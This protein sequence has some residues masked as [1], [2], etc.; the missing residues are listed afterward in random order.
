MPVSKNRALELIDE[1]IKQFQHI[2]DTATYDTR[3]N[4]EYH[5]AY[6]GAES[7]L[8]E[9]FSE[10]E[11]KKFRRN[12]STFFAISTTDQGILLKDYKK[13][14]NKCISQLKVYKERIQ[15]FWE[16]S[17]TI[18]PEKID[19]LKE[20]NG[21]SDKHHITI[22]NNP[23]AHAEA[24]ANSKAEQNIEV[25]IDINLDLKIDLPLIRKEFDN[26]KDELENINPKL[27]SELDKI[28][29]SLDELSTN[30]DKEK[31]A[32][33]FNK[34]YRFL[35]KLSDPDSDYNKVI[36]GTQK[37]IELAQKVG[38]SYNKFAQWLAM[39]QVP[40]LFLGKS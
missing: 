35:D 24:N 23:Q 6:Y 17:E 40:D 5:E 22:I 32:K 39:P 33:P 15:N 12:V 18:E 27:D 16:G 1:K 37:G 14:I 28:L 34:L 20:Y 31:V 19:R 29:D 7:L 36:T 11:E 21:L 8:K 4:T 9:L 3:Y 10:E 38:R 2:L 25:D 13:L 26:L 30:S